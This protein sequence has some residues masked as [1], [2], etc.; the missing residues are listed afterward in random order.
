M[1]F[2]MGK[3]SCCIPEL[4]VGSEWCRSNLV[5]VRCWRTCGSL[6]WQ[7]D[8]V[9]DK[10]VPRWQAMTG[11]FGEEHRVQLAWANIQTEHVPSADGGGALGVWEVG[12]IGGLGG[13]GVVGGCDI[14][15]CS[16]PSGCGQTSEKEY[17][18]SYIVPS[19]TRVGSPILVWDAW[20]GHSITPPDSFTLHC[21]PAHSL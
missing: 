18:G 3:G 11:P 13:L 17:G 21:M 5:A 2:H 7:A 4:Y 15:L 6:M 12:G 19:C 14:A 20:F 8:A 9:G 10:L 16:L 1:H